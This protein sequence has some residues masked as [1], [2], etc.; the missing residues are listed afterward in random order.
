[1]SLNEDCERIAEQLDRIE[2]K[3]DHL[4]LA[5]AEEE[6]AEGPTEDLDGNPLSPAR[7]EFE[8]L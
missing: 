4:I 6:E 3:L 5:L 1:M 2:S 8:P 7:D